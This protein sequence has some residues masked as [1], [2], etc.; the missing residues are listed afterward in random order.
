[1]T[2][3]GDVTRDGFLNGAVTV[4]Q[5]ARGYRAGLDAVLLAASLEAADGDAIA[6]AGCGA[7][8]ALLCAAHR[9]PHC[10]FTGFERETEMAALAREGAT[11]NRFGERVDVRQHDI[12]DRPAALENVYGQSF[13]NPPFFDPSEVRSPG[14]GR[15]HAYLAETPLKAWVLFLCQV[16]KPGGRIT[17]IH[18]AAALADLL[19]LLNPRTGE[20]EV[21]PIRPAPSAPARRILIRARKGLRRGPMTLY[22]GLALHESAGGPSTSRAASCFA[23]G[24]LEWR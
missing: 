11:A 13:A 7:G 6:E 3:A 9:L 1:M 22:D 5:P 21:L 24:A 23:G 12:A 2:A 17:M 18:R 16:T 4:L 8:A 15:E 19:E 20:I 14:E 10:R